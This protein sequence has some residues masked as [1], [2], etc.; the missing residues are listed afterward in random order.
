[1]KYQ[2]F[3]NNVVG[4]SGRSMLSLQEELESITCETVL[5]CPDFAVL[6]TNKSYSVLNSMVPKAKIPDEIVIQMLNKYK[7][8]ISE[9][10]TYHLEKISRV[11]EIDPPDEFNIRITE[12]RHGA[13]TSYTATVRAGISMT[14]GKVAGRT[15]F[16]ESAAVA[17]ALNKNLKVLR[18][19]YDMIEQNPAKVNGVLYGG[20]FYTPVFSPM[21]GLYTLFNVFKSAGYEFTSRVEQ[22]SAGQNV[23]FVKKKSED[24]LDSGNDSPNSGAVLGAN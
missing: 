1:M 20:L 3:Y 7:S 4:N 12:Q 16:K 24:S 17:S 15:Y 23:H 9:I 18:I 11:E 2:A 19:L 6:L 14:C 10:T 5:D 13:L 21:V 22:H 8:K